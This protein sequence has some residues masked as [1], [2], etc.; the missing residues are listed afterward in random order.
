MGKHSETVC[1]GAIAALEALFRQKG[2]KVDYHAVLKHIKAIARACRWTERAV[3]MKERIRKVDTVVNNLTSKALDE[4]LKQ[5]DLG[6]VDGI[7]KFAKEY[8]M[9][10]CVILDC[11]PDKNKVLFDKCQKKRLRLA[12]DLRLNTIKETINKMSYELRDM[13]VET[14]KAVNAIPKDLW[15][16]T[17]GYI[18]KYELAKGSFRDFKEDH[19]AE[20]ER[21][22]SAW[23]AKGRS[24]DEKERRC[25]IRISA[26]HIDLDSRPLCEYGDH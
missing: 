15:G 17:E 5:L 9:N 24:R 13:S 11:Q 14:T 10:M 22:Y 1:P 6:V 8:D 26:Q 16:V 2:V 21:Q 25:E 4:A 19:S 7:V 3:D 20:V 23:I 18:W 12:L